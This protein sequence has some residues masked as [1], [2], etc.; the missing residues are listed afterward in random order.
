VSPAADA[1]HATVAEAVAQAHRHEWGLVLAVT[2]RLAGG[3]VGLAEESTQEAFVAALETWGERG[4]PDNP[5]AW[6]TQTAKRRLLDRLRRDATLRRKLPLLVDRADG[7][8]PAEASAAL[9]VELEGGVIPDERLRLVFTCCHPALAMEARTALTLRLVCGLTTDEIAH[10]FLVSEPTMAARI[11]RAKKKISAAGIPYRVPGRDDLA[12]RLDGVLTVIHLVFTS[13]HT[14]PSGEQ[15]VR[16]DLVE[17]ALD[18]A[19]VMAALLP[20]EPEAL[21]LLALLELTDA[22]R[23]ARLDDAGN[24]VLLEDQDRALWDRVAI[25]HGSALLDRALLIV[26]PDQPPGRF[27]LQAAAAAVHAEAPTFADTDWAALVSLYD[28]LLRAWPSP[29][30]AVNRAVAVSF[31]SGPAAGLAALDEFADDRRLAGYHYL[32][33]TRADFLRRLGNHEAAAQQYRAALAL[34]TAPAERRFLQNRID[35]LTTC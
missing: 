12:E 16:V 8:G 28:Q 26:G 30:V 29:V 5:G 25:A 32:P 10:A 7:V 4:I 6:L 27:L 9:E 2:A 3:D 22:R 21:G 1:D 24:L 15:L 18:L 35:T 23:R 14:A 33:A 13:G 17:R 20:D 34:A 31:A 19:R 11:T